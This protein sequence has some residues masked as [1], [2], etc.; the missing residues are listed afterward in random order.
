MRNKTVLED[1]DAKISLILERYTWLKQENLTVKEENEKLK[2]AFDK[3]QSLIEEKNKEILKLKE[4]D[5]LKDLEL[6]D[7]VFRINK[8][9]GLVQEE[10]KAVA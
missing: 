8:T 1:L 2:V 3:I 5:E 4:E 7:I 10:E 6:E 9:I